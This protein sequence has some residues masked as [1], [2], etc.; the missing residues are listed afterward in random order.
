MADR[1]IGQIARFAPNFRDAIVDKMILTH[2][3]FEKTFGVTQGDF[4]SG[5]IHPGQMWDK[6]P[7]SGWAGYKTPIEGLSI[8]AGLPA[9]P[10][11]ALHAFQG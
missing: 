9:I 6:R 3:Y 7:V 11:P 10:V 1:A 8:C 2:K 5:L 4:T